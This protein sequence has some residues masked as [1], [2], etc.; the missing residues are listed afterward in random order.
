[1][2]KNLARARLDLTPSTVARAWAIP[3][4][5]FRAV[6]DS[7]G[8]NLAGG[9]VPPFSPAIQTRQRASR[10]SGQRP[11][12][13]RLCSPRRRAADSVWRGRQV[14]PDLVHRPGP[15]MA[16]AGGVRLLVGA[17]T[18]GGCTTTAVGNVAG[19]AD[20]RG[21][22]AARNLF[23]GGRTR[24]HGARRQG[25]NGDATPSGAGVV[26]KRRAI[27]CVPVLAVENSR[28]RLADGHRHRD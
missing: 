18:S 25:G 21:E 12:D 2:S 3:R 11:G 16:S 4:E 6:R 22:Y 13:C 15:Q 26:F 10:A 28:A 23:A 9:G 8:R 1:M 17:V 7:A 19:V 14:Q 24:P 20:G 5:E 27:S